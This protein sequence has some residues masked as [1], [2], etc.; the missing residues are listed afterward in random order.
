[1]SS[2]KEEISVISKNLRLTVEEKVIGDI[3]LK[4][5]E[6]SI[7]E[8]KILAKEIKDNCEETFELLDKKSLGIGKDD[9]SGLLGQINV[10]KHQL[11]IKENLNEA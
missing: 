4:T 5:W 1:M 2:S 11:K 3:L 8:S 7:A 6:A 10:I 9:C